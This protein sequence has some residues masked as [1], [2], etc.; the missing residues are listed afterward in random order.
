MGILV[1]ATLHTNG[2]APTIDRIVNAFPADKQSHVRTMLSTSLRGVVSQQLISRKGSPGRVAA[3]ELLVNTPAAANLIR[4]GKI[5]QL[6]TTMQSGAAAGMRT[7][8]SAIEQLHE[9]GLISGRSAYEK[10]IN[11]Q[12]FEP[13]REQD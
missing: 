6:E 3:L 2:A 7:M 11:K 13:L 9:Q 8:D 1:M 12:K 10:S 4:Q 5:D